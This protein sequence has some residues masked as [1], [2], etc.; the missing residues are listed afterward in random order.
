MTSNCE[1]PGCE[2]RE[3]LP[4][5]CRLCGLSYCSKHRLPEMHECINLS[6][7]KTE[8]YRKIKASSS[9]SRPSR[10]TSRSFFAKSTPSYSMYGNYFGTKSFGSESK[11]L[12]FATAFLVSIQFLGLFM[13]YG[14][15]TE[16]AFFKL[17]IIFLGYAICYVLHE[18][19]H[20]VTAVYYGLSARFILWVQGLFVT[21]ISMVFGFGLIAPGFVS[22]EGSP[23]NRQRGIISLAGPVTNIVISILLIAMANTVLSSSYWI[24][25]AKILV[26]YNLYLALFNLFPIGFLDGKK[27]YSWNPTVYI[28]T[29]ATTI[30][31][32]VGNFIR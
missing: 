15:L 5:K 8:E 14:E 29:V 26:S 1:F 7:Y 18:L 20:K 4:F 28:V 16:G 11:D 25:F 3:L 31:L 21:L 19:A 24:L 12:L 32:M 23:T 13:R 17:L 22:T 2:N 27:I 6:Y 9:V 30:I 10:T